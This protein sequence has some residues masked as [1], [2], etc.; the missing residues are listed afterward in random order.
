MAKTKEY[1]NGEVTVVWEAKSSPWVRIGAANTDAII[2]KVKA[3]SSGAL[4]FYMNNEEDKTAE[5]LGTKIEVF[6]NPLLV[7][8]TLSVT[9]KDGTTETKNKTTAFC[10][11]TLIKNSF[12]G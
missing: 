6:R 5:T 4:S 2:N 11:G 8:A 7:Y 12:K 9:H 1:S 3:C 10:D